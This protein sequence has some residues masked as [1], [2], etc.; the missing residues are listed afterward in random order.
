MKLTP[1]WLLE[2][3][4][5]RKDSEHQQALVRIVILTMVAG[6]LWFAIRP[7]DEVAQQLR[8]AFIFLGVEFAV[9]CLIIAWLLWR[10]ERSIPRRLLGMVADYSL[11]GVGMHLLGELLAPLY[12]LIMWVTIGNGLRY[13]PRW[14]YVAIG[15]ASITFLIAINT[16]HYWQ[17]NPWLG[18]GLLAGLIAIPLYFNTLLKALT[19]ATEQAQAASAA[20][21]RFVA[22]MSHE[23][24][25]PLNGII[26]M[27]ELLHTTPM[28][29]E[30]RDSARVI[31]TSARALQ[32]LVEDIL[33]ISA[34][35]AGKLQRNDADFDLVDLL[36]DIRVMLTPM[37][38]A[39]R[40]EFQMDIHPEVPRL[41]NGD[42]VHLRQILVNLLSNA[43]KF[44]EAGRILLKIEVPEGDQEAILLRFDVEDTGIGIAPDAQQRIFHMFEQVDGGRDRRYGG[45]GLGT[46]IA[47]ALAELMGGRIELTSKVGVG[48][49]F[50][51]ELP[52][53]P[54]V[55][56]TLET[57]SRVVPDS[58]NV[59]AFDD[60]FI[61][62]RTRVQP[63]QVLVVDDQEANVL[64]IRR[65]LERAGHAVRWMNDADSVLDVLVAERVDLVITDLHM[66]K[67]SGIEL[68]KQSRWLQA[69][70]HHKTPFIVL[71][72]DA[73][74]EAM[75]ESIQAGAHAV[76][77][78]PVVVARLL[79]AIAGATESEPA[80][81]CGA[82]SR[83]SRPPSDT[84]VMSHDLV[85]ELMQMGLGEDFVH[86]FLQECMRDIRRCFA[87]IRRTA[88]SALWDECRDAHHAL[89]GAAGNMGAKRLE[90]KAGDG[91]R[92]SNLALESTWRRRV[93]DMEKDL[94]EA[95]VALEVRDIVLRYDEGDE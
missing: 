8:L 68:I 71:T 1:R 50:R 18:W 21:T 74:P 81:N 40:L 7:Q 46:T 66:P 43:V 26:G 36:S 37:V 5:K 14:L 48:S 64:V 12:V 42:S 87:E 55:S 91:M 70:Q 73:T 95:L 65:L 56:M 53:H 19:R 59:I 23:L 47:R 80:E 84:S 24:R 75:E 29:G 49:L 9:G 60:P 88:D 82:P 16:T 51:V 85:D 15:M 3:M 83:L 17:Q 10:P 44:T 93:Q 78:K 11:M 58:G 22:T 20:K 63:K 69:G 76:L 54:A 61:R 62:H 25:T 77:H 4:S 45:S 28:S 35:E 34:I 2:R 33:D 39:K 52:M 94:V 67:I 86:S 30:Q 32:L 72:A 57:Q 89:K 13:G 38:Q 27:A 31:L 79:D 92:A 41:L 90:A 6:Y